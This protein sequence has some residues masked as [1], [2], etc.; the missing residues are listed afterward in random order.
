[1]HRRTLRTYEQPDLSDLV[2]HFVA[3]IGP[4]A[5][6]VPGEIQNLSSFDRLVTILETE[7]LRA[8]PVFGSG[9]WPVACFSECTRAGVLRLV[10][11]GRYEPIGIAFSKEYLFDFAGGPAL[12]I[13]GDEWPHAEA[14]PPP[15]RARCT[16]FWPGADPESPSEILPPYLADPSEWTHEREWRV[17][18]TGDPPAFRF[19]RA[20]VAFVVLADHFQRQALIETYLTDLKFVVI[21]QVAYE[22]WDV[23][24][25]WP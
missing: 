16:R 9:S 13:R 25:V 20:K 22:V 1:V 5:A 17:P 6:G 8:F 4:K 23:G 7:E 12:Y 10:A 21:R 14:L 18:G 24:N 3:R 11:E 19:E 2:I 15:L